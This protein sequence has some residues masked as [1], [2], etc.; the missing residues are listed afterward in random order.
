MTNRTGAH[1]A[2]SQVASVAAAETRLVLRAA[3]GVIRHLAPIAAWA[4][5]SIIMGVVV[6]FAAVALPPLAAFG[7]VAVVALVLLWAMPDLPLVYP[8]LIRKTYFIML[9]ADLC[10]P[11]YYTVQVSGLPWISAR[12]LATF[13]LIVPFLLAIASS[14]KVRREIMERLRP[15]WLIVACALGYLVMASVS[16][17]TSTLPEASLTALV[18][19]I[20]SWYLPFFATIYV[21][22]NKDDAI[23]AHESTLLLCVI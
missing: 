16:I 20:L 19:C 17:L 7:I 5:V 8:A 6:G 2:W 10:I 1:I 12:R 18:D 22:K 23:F 9:V 15:S 11:F 21:I 13:S 4:A 14:P 3:P